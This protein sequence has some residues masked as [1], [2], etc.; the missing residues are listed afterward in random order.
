V[1]ES[2]EARKALLR[3]AREDAERD[4][5]Y[6]RRLAAEREAAARRAEEKILEI[7]RLLATL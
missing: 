7:D 3:Y 1:G 2:N 4:V 6:Q 5:V